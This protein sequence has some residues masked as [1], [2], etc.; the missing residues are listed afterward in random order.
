[1]DPRAIDKN[2]GLPEL[3]TEQGDQSQGSMLKKLDPIEDRS[4]DVSGLD[5]ASQ[6]RIRSITAAAAG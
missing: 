4:I 2:E 3:G 5:Q 1:M 6:L